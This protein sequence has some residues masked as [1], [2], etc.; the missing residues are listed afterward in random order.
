M[1][2]GKVL[3]ESFLTIKGNLNLITPPLIISLVIAIMSEA[4]IIAEEGV[5]SAQGVGDDRQ[6]YTK[7]LALIFINYILQVFSQGMVIAMA[8]ELLAKG[9]YSLKGG[10]YKTISKLNR[11]LV[12]SF[13]FAV[14]IIVGI[15]LFIVPAII[16]SFVFMYVFVIVMTEDITSIESFK[17]GFRIVKVNLGASMLIYS[18]LAVT[19]LFFTILDVAL[20]DM[21]YEAIGFT[22]SLFL[23]SALVSFSG[24]VMLKAYKELKTLKSVKIL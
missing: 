10:F 7:I 19:G 24:V 5:N 11:L 22:I 3:K 20:K 12:V 21:E 17:E 9:H 18:S 23:L 16:V 13:I 4:V 1:N 15:F 2:T 14:L 6:F 8:E